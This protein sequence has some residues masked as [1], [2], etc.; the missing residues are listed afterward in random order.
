MA[1]LRKI[2]SKAKTEINTGFG[3]NN[4][5]YGGRFINKD[6][7]PNVE[8][9]GLPFF[10]R[11]SWFHT[12][13][14]MSNTKFLLVIFLFFITVNFFPTIFL[15]QGNQGEVHRSSWNHGQVCCNH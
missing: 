5:A 7:L 8:K 3:T 10:K 4:A 2:N 9:T 1:F 13:L 15:T 14:Q 6:G 12:L 11:I